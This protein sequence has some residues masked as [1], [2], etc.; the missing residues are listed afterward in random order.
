M[1]ALLDLYKGIEGQ[2]LEID[3]IYTV[4]FYNSQP[5]NEDIE[6]SYMRPAC[7]IEFTDIEWDADLQAKSR[8]GNQEKASLSVNIYVEYESLAD[9]TTTFEELDA[10]L[11][12][13]RNKL[14]MYQTKTCAPLRRIAET[15]DIN[16]NN[17]IVWIMT[18]N[19]MI[20]ESGNELQKR[21]VTLTPNISKNIDIDNTII[22]TG[23]GI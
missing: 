13:I 11:I 3:S 5:E 14:L 10:I 18:F 1:S 2:L 8:Y 23:D 6:S 19:T 9:E 21:S 15:P 12:E 4:R 17:K 16:H 7:F 20:Q 22:R